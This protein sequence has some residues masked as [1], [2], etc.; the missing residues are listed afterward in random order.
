MSE[1]KQQIEPKLTR[2][3]VNQLKDKMP[4]QEWNELRITIND[5]EM[6]YLIE[7]VKKLEQNLKDTEKYAKKLETNHLQ[8]V[9]ETLARI[10]KEVRELRNDKS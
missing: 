4:F 1:C 8:H 7:T 5:Q 2:D 10:Q 6:K 3:G 9:Y